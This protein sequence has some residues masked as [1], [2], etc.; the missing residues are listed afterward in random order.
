MR[1]FTLKTTRKSI[2]C[3]LLGI[4]ALFALVITL[5][6]V[7]TGKEVAGREETLVAGTNSQRIAFLAQYGWTVQEEPTEVKDVRIPESFGDVY[8][9]YNKIQSEQGM[10]LSKYQG[11]SVKRWSYTVT[12]YP[13]YEKK[14]CVLANLLVLDGKVIGGDVCSTELDGFMHTFKSKQIKTQ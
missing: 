10:D 6:G 14:E 2:F 3:A 8:T 9:N 12:N 13:G 4:T 11:K 7:S 1:V 5:I